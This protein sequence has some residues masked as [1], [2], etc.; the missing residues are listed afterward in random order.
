MPERFLTLVALA[1][2]QL[3]KRGACLARVGELPHSGPS[4]VKHGPCG[5]CFRAR[6]IIEV[7]LHMQLAPGSAGM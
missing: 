1:A 2:T 7:R 3:P 6:G 4:G 5:C